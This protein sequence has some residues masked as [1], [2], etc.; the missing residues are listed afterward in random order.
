MAALRNLNGPASWRNAEN[1]LQSV[2]LTKPYG[3][4][5]ERAVACLT[6]DRDRLL[7]F[8]TFSAEHWRHLRSTNPIEN[9]VATVRLRT[10]KS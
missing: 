8:Y 3:A 1:S 2:N 7:T 6:K 9:T 10:C 4:T 5:S